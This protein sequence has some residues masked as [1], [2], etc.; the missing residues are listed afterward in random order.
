VRFEWDDIKYLKAFEQAV[1]KVLEK[2]AKGVVDDARKI[3]TSKAKHPTGTL[4]RQ[5]EFKVSQFKDGGYIVEAQGPGN[6]QKYYAIF[7]ELGTSKMKAIPY[8]RPAIK[9]AKFRM[10]KLMENEI[11]LIIK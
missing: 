4:A 6:Y 8:L 2:G 10:R 5:I 9:R 7:V 1:D 3:I 11:G